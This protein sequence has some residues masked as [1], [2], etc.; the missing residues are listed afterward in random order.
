MQHPSL[1]KPLLILAGAAVLLI[2]MR[3]AATF[4]VPILLAVFIAALLTPLY[5][6]LKRKRVPVGLA[7][8]LT[9][10]FMVLLTVF[11]ALLVGNS[12][13]TLAA[14]LS[15]Y[16]EQFSQRQTESTAEGFDLPQLF[17]PAT[18]IGILTFFLGAMLGILKN[19]L[20]I[21]LVTVFVLVESPLFIKR[22]KQAFG[23]EHFLP[24]NVIELAQLMISYFGLRALVN[25]VTATATG[26][27][28]W[29][30]GIEHAGLWAVLTFFLSFIP[31]IGAFTAALPPILLAYAQGGLGFAILIGLLIVVIN[32]VAENI[33]APMVMGKGLSV[34]PTVVFLSFLFWMFILGGSGAFIAMPLTLAVILFMRSFEET[35]SFA[36]MLIIL[37]ETGPQ[38]LQEN[39]RL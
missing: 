12:L 5:R 13:T 31:Y 34:S 4:L 11:L 21:L 32:A 17:D 28:F 26:L 29:F 30:F 37:P 33:V 18:L 24:R 2:A 27:M 36:E 8:L 14:E 7:L 10:S 15:S 3:L 23:A 39:P 6:W 16:S 25:L 19:F 1:I 22:M 38:P 20:I 9:I 35:R